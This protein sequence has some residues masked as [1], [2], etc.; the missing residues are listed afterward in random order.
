MTRSATRKYRAKTLVEPV[1]VTGNVV[2]QNK[3]GANLL[4]MNSNSFHDPED[5]AVVAALIADF[6][7][8]V[9][10]WS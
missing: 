8:K 4:V 2:V 10:R 5:A 1:I 6:L 9:Q 7:T 3:F